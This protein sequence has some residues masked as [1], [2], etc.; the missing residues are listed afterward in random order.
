MNIWQRLITRPTSWPTPHPARSHLRTFTTCHSHEKKTNKSVCPEENRKRSPR[1]KK[2]NKREESDKLGRKKMRKLV[3]DTHFLS[4]IVQRET[5]ATLAGARSARPAWLKCFV[6][7]ARK[8][9]SRPFFNRW[10]RILHQ[11]IHHH[12]GYTK[13]HLT[14]FHADYNLR[15]IQLSTCCFGYKSCLRR[16]HLHRPGCTWWLR[17]QVRWT[18]RRSDRRVKA[19]RMSR[20]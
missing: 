13:Y 1:R 6:G 7:G 15:F 17:E 19:K 4:Q 20:E 10:A 14:L 9:I 3:D 5:A 8:S 11:S 2:R 18:K 16:I 12:V